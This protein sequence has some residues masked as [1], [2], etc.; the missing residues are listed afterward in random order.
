MSSYRLPPARPDFRTLLQSF[1]QAPGL[2]FAEVLTAEHI[3]AA[4]ADEG[5]SFGE[6][7]GQ[8]YSVAVTLW[9]FLAPVL[10]KEKSC[11]KAVARVLVWLIALGRKPCAA[12]TGAY[13]KARAQWPE[14]FLQRLTLDVGRRVEEAAPAGGWCSPMA[15]RCCWPTPPPIR[16]PTRRC[17]HNSPAPAFRFCAW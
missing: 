16:R 6:G 12:G 10:S 5:V 2:P 7:P 13:G 4:C 1:A 15:R 3:P 11:L 14:P 8:V 9:A 17:V